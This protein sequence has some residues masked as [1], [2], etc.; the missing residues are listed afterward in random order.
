MKTNKHK[1]DDADGRK[2]VKAIKEH[3]KRY[4]D[5]WNATISKNS[6]ILF[7][8]CTLENPHDSVSKICAD[9]NKSFLKEVKKKF[10][11]ID[12]VV[13]IESQGRRVNDD[14][15]ID[16]CPHLHFAF[17]GV[18]KSNYKSLKNKILAA[19]T[20]GINAP[21]K[22]KFFDV[23]SV[24][25]STGLAKYLTKGCSPKT[26][27]GYDTVGLLEDGQIVKSAFTDAISQQIQ[28]WRDK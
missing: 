16:F 7:A 19:A 3:G 18:K 2:E 27:E 26:P 10:T 28:R 23:Q 11:H 17:F 13:C 15:S 14:D 22:R 8:T 20:Q 4:A 6:P 21:F 1:H 12:G 24:Y 5:A 9:A 25:D